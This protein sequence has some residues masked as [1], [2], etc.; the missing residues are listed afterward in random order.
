MKSDGLIE[1]LFL[2]QARNPSWGMPQ[3]APV[4]NIFL[5]LPPVD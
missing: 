1:D 5:Y 3:A 4:Y 2:K